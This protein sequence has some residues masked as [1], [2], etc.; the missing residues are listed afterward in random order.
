M[1]KTC[2]LFKLKDIVQYSLS[3]MSALESECSYEQYNG[4]IMLMYLTN[5]MP[6]LFCLQDFKIIKIK[7]F[8]ASLVDWVQREGSSWFFLLSNIRDGI[9]DITEPAQILS[10]F[11]FIW[12]NKGTSYIIMLLHGTNVD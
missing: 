3:K 1:F 5:Y 8:F 11:F 2:K 10:C 6:N 9:M 7:Y 4:G 12:F